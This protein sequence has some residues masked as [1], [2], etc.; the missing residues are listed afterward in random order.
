MNSHN[1]CGEEAENSYWWEMKCMVAEQSLQ[2]KQ[3]PDRSQMPG[4]SCPVG[5]QTSATI[6]AAVAFSFPLSS[7]GKIKVED[8]SFL[9]SFRWNKFSIYYRKL[10]ENLKHI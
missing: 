1:P 4:H 3:H 5:P 10:K 2:W 6:E 8:M 7:P 9:S